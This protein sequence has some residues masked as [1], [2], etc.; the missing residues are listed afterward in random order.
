[1]T[2]H[3]ESQGEQSSTY[4]VQ[5]R[6][7]QEEMARLEIQ[8]KMITA[9]M[10][11]VLPELDNP[12][13]LRQVLDVG[14]GAGC[15]L[16][17]TA[18]TYQEIEKL[19]GVDISG[20]MVA[21]ANI[22]AEERHLSDRVEFQVMDA[23]RLLEFPDATFDLI[24]HRFGNSWLRTW[25]WKKIFLEYLRVT[26]PGGI[27]RIT[28]SQVVESNTPALTKLFTIFLEAFYHAGRYFTLSRDG[29]T[30]HIERLMTEHAIEDVQTRDYSIVYRAGTVEGQQ[31]YEDMLHVF[32]VSLPF[33][34]KF[35]NVPSDYQEI[36]QQALKEMQ[37]P[38]F[39]ATWRL[40]TAWGIRPRDGRA[41]FGR[42]RF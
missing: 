13:S 2:R 18:T 8:D 35:T 27:I 16:M 39:V 1:M 17:E 10:G 40:L 15:W 24:N 23:L 31:F 34:Q 32:R 14:C 19:V 36:Y 6:S 12:A 33:F 26:R 42:G 38:D 21:Y 9:G 22:R 20:K 3:P 30:K 28:E 25:D 41:I 37:Q 7:N 4:F 11:G 5:D 29:I